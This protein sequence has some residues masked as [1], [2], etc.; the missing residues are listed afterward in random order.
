MNLRTAFYRAYRHRSL[1]DFSRFAREATDFTPARSQTFLR[2]LLQHAAKRVPYYVKILDSDFDKLSPLTKPLIRE[3][4]EGI[5]SDDLASRRW[6]LTSSGGATGQPISLVQDRG[7][8]VWS[9]VAE[10]FFWRTML[11][12][13][14]GSAPTVVLWGSEQDLFGQRAG[15]KPRMRNWMLRTTF[16]NSFKMTPRDLSRYADVIRDTNPAI[17]KGYASSLYELARF[18]KEHNL[19]VRRPQAIYSA[20]EMLRLPMR[21]LI[22]EVFGCKVH[23]FYGS[24][25]VGPI[26]GECTRGKLHVFAFNNLVEVVGAG[27]RPVSP[28]QEGRVLVTTLHNYA[29]PLI[30]YEIGDTAVQGGGCDCGLALPTLER[31]SGRVTDHFVT[32]DGALVHGEYFTHLFYFKDWVREFQVVQ[33]DVDSI[34]IYYATCSQ[35]MDADVADINQKIRLVMGADCRIEWQVVEAVPRT[36][37][38][39]L[40]F[41]RSL[42]TTRSE[43]GDAAS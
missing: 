20:A 27:N 34:H 21:E 12:V 14:L 39:K 18:I 37:Q 33:V 42:V 26:A 10:D 29:M 3:N 11:G 4:F 43:R 35:R 28:G 7:F 32:R 8:Q 23:D 38:G 22:E 30:R 24:R 41:T 31:V 2:D 16:L 25:E 13:E 6:V 15:F 1:P 36:P 9:A 40:L 19:P 5:K 17:L